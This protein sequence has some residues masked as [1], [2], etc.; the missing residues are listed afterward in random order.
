MNIEYPVY[1]IHRDGHVFVAVDEE[2]AA[3]CR[4]DGEKHRT[5]VRRIGENGVP[6]RTLLVEAE[7]IARDALGGIVAPNDIPRP[8]RRRGWWTRR[9]E[10]A[11]LAA[12][13]GL[14]IPGTG[15]NFGRT[16]SSYRR[17][18]AHYGERRDNAALDVEIAEAGLEARHVLRMRKVGPAPYEDASWRKNQRNWKAQR[19]TRW[20]EGG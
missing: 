10:E 1:F 2:T 11:A 20:K 15:R 7:W 6:E 14:P 3:Q 16:S 17:I 9:L 4:I 5:P 19:R 8:R 12:A 18:G 13:K